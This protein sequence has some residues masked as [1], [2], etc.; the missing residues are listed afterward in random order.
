MS[1]IRYR[2]LHETLYAYSAPV[3]LSHQLL[4]LTPR[5]LPWQRTLSNTI[6]VDPL[7]EEF[8]RGEDY[9]GNPA[10]HMVLVAPHRALSVRAESEL[11]VLPRGNPALDP[12]ATR[13]AWDALRT[14]MR[15]PLQVT[16]GDPLGGPANLAAAGFLYESPYVRFGVALAA[17]AQPSFPPARPVAEAARDLMRRIHADFE[18]D[19]AAT[20]VATPLA[21][22]LEARRGVCQDFAHLMVGCLRM[23]GL[24]ARYVSG[25]ILTTP[26]P[27]MPRL[28]GADAS[29]A[30]VS[31]WCGSAGGWLDL[32]P[33]NDRVVDQEYI[34]LGWGRDF[35]DVTPMRGVILGGGEQELTVR[36]TVMPSI[37]PSPAPPGATITAP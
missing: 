36:V 16:E 24:A 2:V 10:C 33:T 14:R 25:Y 15:A 26:P 8:T 6:T 3:A 32:D 4:H 19:P 13:P 21:E 7:P 22:V 12:A 34:T 30:W 23:Q 11:E 5:A 1:A 27:G 28:I 29:H 20:S 37:E 9:F 35:G 31:V 18:F 17:Y